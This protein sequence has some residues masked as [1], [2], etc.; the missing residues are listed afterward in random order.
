MKEIKINLEAYDVDAVDRSPIKY[1][2]AVSAV[3]DTLL[4]KLDQFETEHAAVIDKF[5]EMSLKLRTKYVDS[6]HLT[7]GENLLLYNRQQ[8]LAQDIDLGIDDAEEQIL[9][10]K[11]QVED[12]SA[13]IDRIN[14]LPNSLSELAALEAECRPSFLFLIE[15]AVGIINNAQ[16]RIDFFIQHQQFVENIINRW[17]DWNEDYEAFKTSKREEFVERN[18]ASRIE[19][20]IWQGWYADW[21]SKRF[22]IENKFL[23]LIEFALKGN[24]LSQY[25]EKTAAEYALSS[26]ETYKY[27]VDDFYILRRRNIYQK[28][29]VKGELQRLQEK[30]QRSL[31]PMLDKCARPEEKMFLL[32]WAQ[33]LKQ[34][35]HDRQ[36]IAVEM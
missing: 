34:T 22:A 8:T 36:D 18:S 30:F 15:N 16:R 5:A 26:L 2:D 33:P 20:E 12:I 31:Q 13:R 23:P 24:L 11:S 14:H 35:F 1:A 6:R 4:N 3:A 21:Q 19:Q 17:L 25:G 32:H 7:E 29:E 9:S 10:I 27:D 28:S